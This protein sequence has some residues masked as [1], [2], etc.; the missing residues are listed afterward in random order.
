MGPS[1][2]LPV[3]PYP[4]FQIGRYEAVAS[5]IVQEAKPV[6]NTEPQ[7]SVLSEDMTGRS[8]PTAQ[9]VMDNIKDAP[10]VEGTDNKTAPSIALTQSLEG[11][12]GADSEKSLDIYA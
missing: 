2:N 4:A 12:N 7:V 6:E 11:T 3:M 5:E 1:S 8:D 9:A 10:P